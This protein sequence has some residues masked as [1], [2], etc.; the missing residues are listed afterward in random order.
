MARSSRPGFLRQ[1][2]WARTAAV[3]VLLCGVIATPATAQTRK[4]P[5]VFD[6]FASPFTESELGGIGCLVASAAAT[7]LTV[8]LMGGLGNIATAMEGVPSPS[9]VLQGAAAG[10]F[11][12][13]SA[14]YIGQAL[15]PLA[16]LTYYTIADGVAGQTP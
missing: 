14:C 10:A 1:V 8:W 5:P 2:H 4:A 16:L 13:S 3:L 15:S 12:Y 9:W 11:V 7:G 6:Q